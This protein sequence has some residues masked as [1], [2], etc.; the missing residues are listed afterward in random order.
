MGVTTGC[1]LEGPWTESELDRGGRDIRMVGHH[2]WAE[3]RL[4]RV[5]LVRWN[6]SWDGS[7][8]SSSSDRGNGL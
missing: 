2:L 6:V 1:E 4:G 3:S 8:G 7:T 5:M